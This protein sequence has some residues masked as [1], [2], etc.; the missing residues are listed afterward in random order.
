M[1]VINVLVGIII[2]IGVLTLME[3]HTKNQITIHKK[4]S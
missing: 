4:N 2:F 3:Q 1:N